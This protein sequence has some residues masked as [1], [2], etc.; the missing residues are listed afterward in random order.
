MKF[1]QEQ[2]M[3]KKEEERNRIRETVID[4]LKQ[5]TFPSMS[6]V[7]RVV[8]PNSLKFHEFWETTKRAREELRNA[9][10][11]PLPLVL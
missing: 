2:S 3:T 6:A 8:P 1:R 7:E 5:G 10:G 4:L 11:S 9:K